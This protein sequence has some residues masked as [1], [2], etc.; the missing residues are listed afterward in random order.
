MDKFTVLDLLKLDLKE[1]DALNLRCITGRPGLIREITIPEL[2]RP[3]LALTG[4]FDKFA[5][6]RIQ[7]CGR[8][9][10]AYPAKHKKKDNTG[11]L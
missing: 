8:G 2:D 5:W 6:K 11:L 1:H 4:F 3:G 7:G 9:E 10:G